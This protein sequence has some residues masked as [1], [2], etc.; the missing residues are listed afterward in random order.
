MVDT[1]DQAGVRSGLL[2][3]FAKTKGLASFDD[4]EEEPLRQLENQHQLNVHVE[5]CNCTRPSHHLRGSREKYDQYFRELSS[6]L[7]K[8]EGAGEVVVKANQ[9]EWSG[10]AAQPTTRATDM[11][12]QSMKAKPKRPASAAATGGRTPLQPMALPAGVAD[13]FGFLTPQ[14]GRWPRVG[15]FEVNYTLL[16]VKSKASY[17]PFLLSSKLM[18]ER[19]PNEAK[20]HGHLQEHLQ[21]L[22]KQDEQ[23]YAL[24]KMVRTKTLTLTLP[25]PLTLPLTLPLPLPLPLPLTL[26]LTLTLARLPHDYTEWRFGEPS[27][28]VSSALAPNP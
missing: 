6:Y 3:E 10:V 23:H 22:L 17:G 13:Q 4:E 1:L 12:A 26:T 25:L 9:P 8:F 24:E 11:L 20:L 19:W 27:W 15:S 18:T 16:N 7:R 14:Q 5:H 28:Y 21:L 2:N